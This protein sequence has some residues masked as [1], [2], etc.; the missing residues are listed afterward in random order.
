MYGQS[1]LAIFSIKAAPDESRCKV[2]SDGALQ[3]SIWV[4]I[5]ELRVSD[6]SQSITYCS[7]VPLLTP[8]RMA[9]QRDG[10]RD[11][12]REMKRDGEKRDRDAQRWEDTEIYRDMVAW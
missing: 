9:Y 6:H 11:R 12:A 10:G 2:P 8:L 5:R 3:V 7:V 4:L 1:D